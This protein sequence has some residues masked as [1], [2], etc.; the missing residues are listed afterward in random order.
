MF[1]LKKS[2]TFA[3]FQ[4]NE[5]LISYTWFF[6]KQPIFKQLALAWQIA[7]Q[8]SG[9]NPFSLSNNKNY[10]LKK[11][12]IAFLDKRKIAVKPT[13]HQNSALSKTFLRK[14]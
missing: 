13:I 3:I 4:S 10:I 2:S 14:F 6:Y 12:V 8:L 9:L 5:A 1:T 11:N 7:K